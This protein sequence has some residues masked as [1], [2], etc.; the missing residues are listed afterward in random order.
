MGSG[1]EVRNVKFK[2]KTVLGRGHLPILNVKYKEPRTNLNCGPTYRDWQWQEYD[3]ECEGPNVAGTD[4]LRICNKPPRTIID[5]PINPKEEEKAGFRG[6]AF[7]PTEDAVL[8][9][10][11][12]TADW[13]RYTTE[14]TLCANG[15]IKPRWVS[16]AEQPADIFTKTLLAA[17]FRVHRD[18][19]MGGRHSGHSL[20][21]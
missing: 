15:T 1:L 10:S 6:I 2:G 3:F 7:Y 11:Y 20:S 18:F 4:Y 21:Q 9:R 8:I 13:Y 12:L 5:I 14:W 17:P 19:L 16:T